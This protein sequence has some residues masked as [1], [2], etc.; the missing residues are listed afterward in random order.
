MAEFL[1]LTSKKY[2]RDKLLNLLFN[3]VSNN[4]SDVISED[5][6]LQEKQERTLDKCQILNLKYRF[7]K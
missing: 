2:N 6:L 1:E 3:N 4:I 7:M 5:I